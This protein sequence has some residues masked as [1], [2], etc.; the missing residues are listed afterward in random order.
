AAR[1]ANAIADA[2]IVEQL[3]TKYQATRRASVWLQ[4]RIAE[5][6]NQSNTAAREVQDYKAKNSIIDTGARGLL[7]DLQLQEFNTQMIAAAGQTAEAKARLERIEAV[8]KSPAPDEALGTVS[9]TLKND[10]ITGLRTKYLAARQREA[11]WSARFGRTH[12]REETMRAALQEMIKQAGVSGQAQVNLRELESAAQTYRTIFENFLQKYTEAVQQQSFPV[13]EARLITAATRPFAKSHPKTA[14]IALLGLL[15]GTGL[16]LGHAIVMRNFDRVLRTPKEVEQ[17]TGFDCL[18]LVPIVEPPEKPAPV[19]RTPGQGPPSTWAKDAPAPAEQLRPIDVMDEVVRSP[20]SRFTESLRAARTS[21]DITALTRPMKCI[22]VISAVP[23]EG[24]S[25]ISVNLAKLFAIS[26]RTTLLI[27]GDMRNPEL[28]RTLA[29]G[30]ERGLIEVMA[31]SAALTNAIAIDPVTKLA[32]LPVVTRQRI[33]NSSDLLASDEMRRIL[34]EAATRF[35][36]IIVDLPPLGAVVDA[37]AMSPHID[38]FV[39]VVE[40]RKTRYDVLNEAL[41][42][43]G[44]A[45]EKIVGVVLNKVNYRELNDLDGYS[46]GYYHN[47][48]YSR[49]G[50]TQQ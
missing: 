50:Y 27:D 20:L 39:V 11:D 43:F 25:T 40:W 9:D 29:D 16:G 44:V 38:A 21:I 35:E 32:F 49:Y 47:K 24:K 13:S 8:L 12:P 6:R 26:G 36:H 45:A 30:A 1:V 18:A 4:E 2:Y 17:R 28:S 46:R 5:L 19:L 34:A 14:L 15:A 10:V 42:G 33:A 7:S 41:A 22:G 48:F 37:R 31:G 23:N 3:D